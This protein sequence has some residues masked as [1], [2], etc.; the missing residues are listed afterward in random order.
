MK[1]DKDNPYRAS[2]AVE[3]RERADSDF[4]GNTL[5]VQSLFAPDGIYE[6]HDYLLLG[7]SQYCRVY[8][9]SIYPRDVYIGW[10][11][12]VFSLGDIDI[13]V[14][15]DPVP[16]RQVIKKLTEIVASTRAQHSVLSKQGNILMLPDWSRR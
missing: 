8:A 15:I 4:T 2:L 7:P 16:D 1:R 3:G 14:H 10:L 9:L 11:D 5:R 13:S 12:D 6:Y